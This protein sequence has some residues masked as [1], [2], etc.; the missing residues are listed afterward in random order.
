MTL[1]A[2]MAWPSGQLTPRFLPADNVAVATEIRMRS[3][4]KQAMFMI[5]AARSIGLVCSSIVFGCLSAHAQSTYTAASCNYSDVNA[6]VNGPTH[7]AVNG[8]TI[9]VP[10]GTCTWTSSL[11]APSGI[12]FTL[13]GAGTPQAGAANVGAATPSTLI[14]VNTGG[15][16]MHFS[17][18]YG[19]PTMRVSM[20]A[21]DPL[22]TT[23]ALSDPLQFLGTCTSS[24]CPNVR[25]D[26]ITFGLHT[27]WSESGNSANAEAVVL[28]NDCFGVLD[29][30]TLNA[31][32]GSGEEIV[33]SENGVYLG[34]GQYGD[35]SW[36]QPD[37]LGGAN[38]LFI[39]NNLVNTKGYLA[40]TD[41]E[42]SIL[43]P[44]RGGARQ[45]V[46]YNTINSSGG[47]GFFG[48]F[49]DHGT[50]SGGRARGAREAEIYHNTLNCAGTTG[51]C[52][53]DGAFR[54]GTGMIFDNTTNFTA[55][56][57]ASPGSWFQLAIYR[58]VSSWGGSMDFCGGGGYFDQNDGVVYY[59]G[60]MTASGGLTMTDASK[61]FSSLNPSGAPYSVYDV[62]HG[63]Y[64][65]IV[66]NT[67]TTITV[68][69]SVG[70]TQ[71]TWSGFT[72]GDSYQVLRAT[73]C[74]DQPGRGQ[75]HYI[76]G[77]S[78]DPTPPPPPGPTGWLGDALDPIYQWGDVASGGS[79]TAMGP[80]DNDRLLNNRD[81][82]AQASGIQTSS[83]SPFNGTSGTGWGT[84]ANRPTTCTPYVGYFETDANSGNGEL[85]VCTN[86]DVWTPHY[87]PY[88]YPHPLDGGIAGTD[89]NPPAS[90][91]NLTAII[92]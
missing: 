40:L 47:S 48:M 7:T 33:N 19:A 56:G 76:S 23:T 65:E 28:T 53:V 4:L 89:A 13:M 14:I 22:T 72:N 58:N 37:S 25:V 82:Y 74:A 17:P 92:Q 69:A 61:S 30:N 15:A 87:Q 18:N 42:Q 70:G 34:V 32:T 35:N 3:F 27:T 29:H 81:F 63:F 5:R 1:G 86:T 21:I 41:S 83:S 26:N 38:N 8:D 46:R 84:A 43:Y 9:H 75:G 80:D 55:G 73:I 54:S 2:G 51:G 16:L 45:V 91:T 52:N 6:V 77:N 49:Q 36:A 59:S 64:S 39:E 66:S 50:D 31:G 60:T 20:M 68:R 57:F 90:P 67:S 12:G 10:A 88:T 44:I 71:N 24:G 11:T 62:T 78:S 85:Y 79:V